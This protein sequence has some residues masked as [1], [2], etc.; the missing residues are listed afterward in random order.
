MV[1]SKAW[2]DRGPSIGPNP[3]NMTAPDGAI[4]LPNDILGVIRQFQHN[5]L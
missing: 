3:W 2:F 4:A 5:C 1:P